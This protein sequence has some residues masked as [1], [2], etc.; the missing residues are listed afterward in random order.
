MPEN[1][2][3]LVH[4]LEKVDKL[5]EH[6]GHVRESQIRMEIDVKH[7]IRRTDEIQDQTALMR[8]LENLIRCVLRWFKLSK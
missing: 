7:H 8:G 3:L 1:K 4:I 6:V 5:E 2:A